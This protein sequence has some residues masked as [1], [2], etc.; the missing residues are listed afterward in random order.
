MRR[1]D[2]FAAL[3]GLTLTGS[4]IGDSSVNAA[5]AV[6]SVLGVSLPRGIRRSLSVRGSARASRLSGVNIAPRSALLGVAA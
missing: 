2:V 4:K 1:P 5:K 6:S 3:L